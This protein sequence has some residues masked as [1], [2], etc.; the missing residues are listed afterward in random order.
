MSSSL[1]VGVLTFHRCINYGSYWQARC[2]VEGLRALGHDAVLLDHDSPAVNR[3]EWR[4]ALA[5]VLPEQSPASDRQFYRAKIRKFQDVVAA[6]PL[7]PAFDLA[8]PEAMDAYDL[9]VVGSDEVW[10]LRHPWYGGAP[11]FFGDG[12]QAGRLISYAAS[13]GNHDASGGLGS[14]WSDWLTRFASISVR[15]ANSRTLVREA[16]SR[17][18]AIVLDPCLQFPP[19]RDC[20]GADGDYVA[21]YGHGFPSWFQ[22]MVRA[23]AG[24]HGRSLRSIGYRNDWADEQLLAAG[25]HEFAAQMAGAR[26]VVTNFFHGYVFAL[27]NAKPFACP[28]TAYRLNKVRDLSTLLG[29]E[30]RLVD[31]QS[32]QERVDVLL[33]EP[34]GDG[35]MHRIGAL[36][37]ASFD[38]LDRALH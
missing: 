31:E 27:L 10:N 26:A 9:V 5:P 16:T 25:P 4:C 28:P 18:P 2:L 7:S 14:P 17:S 35:V 22:T 15:D 33:C 34:P 20:A 1:S 12:L 38:Y 13:F 32:S 3:A 8:K 37:A 6:L 30:E 11:A 19:S 24:R 36:R 21:V 29:L 23:W